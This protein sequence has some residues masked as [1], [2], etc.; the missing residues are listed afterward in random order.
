M[1]AAAAADRAGM[2]ILILLALVHDAAEPDRAP[3]ERA[4]PAAGV[5][6]ENSRLNG[7][8]ARLKG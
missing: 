8:A 4:Q 2:I 1:K 3:S 6:I 5:E 7:M